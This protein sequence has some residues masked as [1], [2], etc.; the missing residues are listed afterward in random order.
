M[1]VRDCMTHNPISVRPESDPLAA[2]P[3][4]PDV[5]LIRVWTKSGNMP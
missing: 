3:S 2:I 4:I 1:L 5:Q